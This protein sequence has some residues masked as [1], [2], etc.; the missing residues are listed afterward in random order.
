MNVPMAARESRRG[1]WRPVRDC[2]FHA[3]CGNDRRLSIGCIALGMALLL[4][5]T[6]AG[7]MNPPASSIPARQDLV[8]DYRHRTPL[9]RVVL[10]Y[11]ASGARSF[12]SRELR[13]RGP[14]VTVSFPKE[15]VTAPGI[16]YYLELLSLIHI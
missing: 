11:R 7:A 5:D 9:A 4:P 6:A 15:D 10:R 8:F 12:R 14:V 16:E 1:E 13:P 2:L 3:L